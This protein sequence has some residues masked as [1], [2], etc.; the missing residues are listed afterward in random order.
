MGCGST[1]ELISDNEFN[2]YFYFIKHQKHYLFT[3]LEKSPNL[4]YSLLCKAYD[5]NIDIKLYINDKTCYHN[6][7]S[8]HVFCLLY[9]VGDL[10]TISP[11]SFYGMN[12]SISEDL[13]IK[14]L[15]KLIELGVNIHTTNTY[16][17]TIMDIINT[18]QPL[19]ERKNNEKFIKKL[20]HYYNIETALPNTEYHSKNKSTNKQGSYEYELPQYELSEKR[21]PEYNSIDPTECEY[22]ILIQE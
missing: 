10:I 21:P 6:W 9:C 13:G 12:T 19:T 15:D 2:Y 8:N 22:R 17:C 5:Q 1:K 16:N 20:I 14:I 18:K 4:Y 11:N 7:Y 3:I